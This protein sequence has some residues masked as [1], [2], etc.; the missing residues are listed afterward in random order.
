MA[1]F[2]WAY[3]LDRSTLAE[4]VAAAAALELRRECHSLF[5]KIRAKTLEASAQRDERL[6]HQY[7]F[8][9]ICAKT[10]YNMSGVEEPVSPGIPAPFDED[11][12]EWVAPI[13][14]DFARYLGLDV[15]ACV[16]EL[17]TE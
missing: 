5:R 9:E 10:L 6:E 11:S 15:P 17:L 3:C 4:I 12:A 16:S 2:F 8:E 14:S 13:A 1:V 7:L